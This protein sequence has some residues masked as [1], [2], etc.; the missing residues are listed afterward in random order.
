MTGGTCG[1]P[2]STGWP[3]KGTTGDPQAQGVDTFY[4]FNCQLLAH[5]YYPD[6]LWA[7]DVQA[8]RE[9][10]WKLVH[11]DI[12][13][14]RPRYELYNLDTDPGEE[15]DRAATEPEIVEHLKGRM[16]E[17]HVPTPDFPVLP[18]E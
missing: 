8:V 13:S 18:G 3:T 1:R 6:H 14:E 11:L 15:N 4:G 16:R 2:T 7:D 10:P 17:A 5:S 12:R 9:G